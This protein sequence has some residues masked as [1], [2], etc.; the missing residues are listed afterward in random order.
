MGIEAIAAVSRVAARGEA[1]RSLLDADLLHYYAIASAMLDDAVEA[2]DAVHD[3]A[4]SAWQGFDDLRDDARFGAWFDRILVNECRDRLRRRGRR[5][6]VDIAVQVE[7]ALPMSPDPAPGVMDT[8][9]VGRALRGLDADHVA[10]VILRYEADLPV[11]AIAERMG[12]A[13]GTVKSRLHYALR[14]LRAALDDPEVP[15]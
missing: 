14:R 5:P 4:V 11:A 6:V 9:V 10:V 7:E 8:I 1:F 13:E 3:A 2:Q 15:R 12:I